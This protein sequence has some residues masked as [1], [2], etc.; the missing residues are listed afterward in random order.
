MITSSNTSQ[1]LKKDFFEMMRKSVDQ[2]L[3]KNWDL[4]KSSWG[5][6][7]I[8]F[9]H[10]D[11][12]IN[13]VNI[14][15]NIVDSIL[16]FKALLKNRSF[17]FEEFSTLLITERQ[18]IFSGDDFSAR[19]LKVFGLSRNE[20]S[21][22][23]ENCYTISYLQEI[24]QRIKNNENF[25]KESDAKEIA[26]CFGIDSMYH[27]FIT[28][29]MNQ[30]VSNNSISDLKEN[31]LDLLF[32]LRKSYADYLKIPIYFDDFNE[33][34]TWKK[35]RLESETG[36][37]VPNLFLNHIVFSP[38]NSSLS[39]SIEKLEDGLKEAI[40]NRVSETYKQYIISSQTREFSFANFSSGK[41]KLSMFDDD[42]IK[43]K[44]KKV[45]VSQFLGMGMSVSDKERLA[46]L[47]KETLLEK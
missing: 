34:L 37:I 42:S 18:K 38:L 45:L 32:F 22:E 24:L 29:S 8:E 17:S 19:F 36:N 46:E 15:S 41:K 44:L 30:F 33:V 13:S 4:L 10:Q 5:E 40:F 11:T 27:V 43:E 23:F 7:E 3:N 20:D 26:T 35:S 21:I 31:L 25:I 14:R 6:V 1:S 2:N 9:S 47:I 39:T 28:N 12:T 16:S